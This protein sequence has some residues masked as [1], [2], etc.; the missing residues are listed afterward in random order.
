MN[1]ESPTPSKSRYVTSPTSHP[2]LELH[3]NDFILK[4]NFIIFM[5]HTVLIVFF[6]IDRNRLILRTNERAGHEET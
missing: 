2:I 3:F 6:S 4:S 5:H 1:C